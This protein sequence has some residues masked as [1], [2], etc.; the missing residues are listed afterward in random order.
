MATGR[1]LRSS[2]DWLMGPVPE[3]RSKLKA[4]I[5][6]GAPR[7]RG[8]ANNSR[9]I[10]KSH[11]GS[12]SE[13]PTCRAGG[14]ARNALVCPMQKADGSRGRTGYLRTEPGRNPINLGFSSG[15]HMFADINQ[16]TRCHPPAWD[17]CNGSGF[18]VSLLQA[19]LDRGKRREAKCQLQTQ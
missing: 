15:R 5:P 11:Q 12:L 8:V 2:L 13:A 4:E 9:R 10:A 18:P 14:S 17:A 1:A 3:A 16:R 19:A 6:P 7:L